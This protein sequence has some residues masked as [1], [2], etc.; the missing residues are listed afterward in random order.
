MRFRA[1]PVVRARRSIAKAVTFADWAGTALPVAC[2][3]SFLIA[4]TVRHRQ[5]LRR[6]LAQ[7]RRWGADVREATRAQLA[8]RLSY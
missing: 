2:T 7:S 4:R 3:G 6:E 5:F 1:G 8:D